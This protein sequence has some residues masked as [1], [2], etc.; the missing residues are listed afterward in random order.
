MKY[1]QVTVTNRT[2]GACYAQ[3]QEL[4]EVSTGLMLQQAEILPA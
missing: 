4:S 3:A 2:I 1:L